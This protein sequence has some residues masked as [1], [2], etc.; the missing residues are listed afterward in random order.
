[1]FINSTEIQ[2][3]FHPSPS[4]KCLQ[5][6]SFLNFFIC[7]AE[8][9]PC[10]VTGETIP[11]YSISI[12]NTYC[13]LLAFIQKFFSYSKVLIIYSKRITKSRTYFNFSTVKLIK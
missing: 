7:L 12:A 9:A 3:K 10:R 2:F 4:S 8:P 6:P 1:M 13:P 11:Y 5:T